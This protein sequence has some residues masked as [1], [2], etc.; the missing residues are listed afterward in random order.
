MKLTSFLLLLASYGSTGFVPS[1]R[2]VLS[3]RMYAQQLFQNV[4]K[5]N[6][7]S[8]NEDVAATPQLGEEQK[9]EQRKEER[10]AVILKLSQEQQDE[11]PKEEFYESIIDKLKK[12]LQ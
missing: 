5:L 1:H 9:G 4:R 2:G 12:D 7:K 3:Q 10:E 8:S 11:E 6:D